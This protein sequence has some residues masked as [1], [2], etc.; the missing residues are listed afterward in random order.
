MP[1][2][3]HPK[4]LSAERFARAIATIAVEDQNSASHFKIR[5]ARAKLKSRNYFEKTSGPVPSAAPGNTDGVGGCLG[6]GQSNTMHHSSP[7]HHLFGT[8]VFTPDCL[9]ISR[10]LISNSRI[11]FSLKAYPTRASG[12]WLL[13]AVTSL[14]IA[15]RQTYTGNWLIAKP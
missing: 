7:F 15:P 4:R 10:T 3:T 11:A 6:R 13:V 14:S 1:C 12:N 9:S 2:P 5:L 8:T